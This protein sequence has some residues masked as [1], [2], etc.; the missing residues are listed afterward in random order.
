MV[1]ES[2][3]IM[4]LLLE[5]ESNNYC[6]LFDFSATASEVSLILLFCG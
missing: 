6:N 4:L 5:V 1:V 2:F 3:I